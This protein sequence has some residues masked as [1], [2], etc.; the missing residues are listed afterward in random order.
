MTKL[1]SRFLKDESGATAIEYGLIA[2][3]ISV[4]LITGATTLGGK[5]STTFTNL[6]TK[7]DNA[8]T[9]TAAAPSN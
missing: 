9:A 3:L 2:A 4:A 1:F 7:M 8:V 6:G 5:I